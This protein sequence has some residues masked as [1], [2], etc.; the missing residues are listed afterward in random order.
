MYNESFFILIAF[1]CFIVFAFKGIKGFAYKYLDEYASSILKTIT[2]SEAIKEEAESEL[3]AVKVR[4][5]EISAEASMLISEAKEEAERIIEATKGSIE[6]LLHNKTQHML[7]RISRYEEQI[8]SEIKTELIT[9]VLRNV[10]AHLSS[11]V[12]QKANSEIV[13]S[14]LDAVKK[15]IH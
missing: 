12:T 15:V 10:E 1:I 6:D 11:Q 14:S 4:A 8:H 9:H 2:E 5:E 7:A 13:A 3:Q